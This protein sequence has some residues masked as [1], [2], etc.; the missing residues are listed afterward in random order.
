MT[1]GKSA[2]LT[3]PLVLTGIFVVASPASA[4]EF[5]DTDWKFASAGGS[6]ACGIDDSTYL[7]CWGNDD[8]GQLGNSTTPNSK[9]EPDRIYDWKG[10]TVVSAGG[11]HTCGIRSGRLYCWGSDQYGQLGNGRSSSADKPLP[12]Q[13]S[14]A[15]DWVAVTAGVSHTCAIRNI[16]RKGRMLACWGDDR[17]GQIGN[18]SLTSPTSP[19]FVSK[20][21]DWRTVTAGGFHTC[22]IR[23]IRTKGSMLACWG[24]DSFGQ[25]G[26]GDLGGPNR[27]AQ[28][29]RAYDWQSVSAGDAHTCAIRSNGMLACWGSDA[30]GQIG[31]G[32]GT[33]SGPDR[34]AQVAKNL[35]T[36]WKSASAGG[37]HSCG[38]RGSGRLYCWG[39]NEYGQTMASSEDA[40]LTSPQRH[41]GSWRAQ[42]AG[43]RLTCAIESDQQLS[44]WGVPEP[45]Q[46]CPNPATNIYA[47]DPWEDLSYWKLTTP[48]DTNDDGKPDEIK[49]PTLKTLDDTDYFLRS[50][51]PTRITFRARADGVTTSGSS[52]PRSELREMSQADNRNRAAWSSKCNTHA[53]T[54]TQAIT[55]QPNRGTDDPVVAGQIHDGGENVGGH[56]DVVM[57]RLEGTRLFVEG[58][59][60]DFGTLDSSY[61]LNEKFTVVLTA[62]SGGIDV[63]YTPQVGST[64]TIN[65]I[66]PLVNNE[67]WYFKAGCYTQANASNGDGYGEVVIYDLDVEHS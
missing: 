25:V 17:Q 16:S 66:R 48:I 62:N 22:G 60:R 39:S 57:I 28:V 63:S 41:P 11:T 26:N 40:L 29:S 43:Q 9:T 32:G 15:T 64:V 47:N 1:W 52:F 59:G 20:A 3:I 54:I 42:D 55:A 27:P 33:G 10:W 34:P 45:P 13:I 23:S 51:S 21:T 7:Y 14:G 31:N 61:E 53:M 49:Q 35:P 58:D 19:A 4:Q 50:S 2:L 65:N 6:H 18:G 8:D 67:Q 44:C 56:G 36:D 46:D 5:S 37:K 12:Q 24:D 38:I 30:S